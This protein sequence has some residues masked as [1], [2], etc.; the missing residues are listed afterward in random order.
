LLSE[1][2]PLGFWKLAL[3]TGVIWGIWHIPLILLGFQFP[4]G[5]VV[6]IFTMIIATLAWSPIYTYLTVRA[7][8]VLAATFFYGSFILGVFTSEFR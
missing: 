4:D 2:A 3:W 8:S 7:R 5:S 1:L 6:G